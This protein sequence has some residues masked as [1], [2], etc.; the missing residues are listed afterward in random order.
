[1]SRLVLG[2][3]YGGTSTKLLLAEHG[4]RS[5]VHLD[6]ASVPTPQGEEPLG[7][8]VAA[9]E[10][11]LDGREIVAAAVTVAG[12]V[13]ESG[14][15]VT[16]ANLPWIEGTAIGDVLAA[17]LGVPVTAVHDGRAAALAEA[18]L[19]AGRGH[20]DLYVVTLGTGIAGAHVVGGQIRRGAHGAAGEVGH[21]SQDDAGDPCTCG[22]RGCLETLVGGAHLARRW[23]RA[24]ED[25]GRPDATVTA[26]DLVA[27]ARAGDHLATGLLSVSTTALA[28][29]LLAVVAT[30]DPGCLVIGGGL[31]QAH[32]MV[33]DPVRRE[34]H[35][36]ATF[37]QVPPVVP[38][39]LG[40]WAGAWGAVLGA[41]DAPVGAART[42]LSSVAPLVPID[43]T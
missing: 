25:D 24:L 36:R 32:D 9:V 2:V 10:G 34:L 43:R 38:A 18:L 20:D 16:S 6:R 26:R 3:D 37:H 4:T 29:G 31:G 23:R 28:R 12:I 27:A 19:G 22:Q 7:G 30:V 42:V 14:V 41:P 39:A 21:V 11:F 5:P 40:P 15:V 8:L 1:M 33:V 17:R 35:A 13:D